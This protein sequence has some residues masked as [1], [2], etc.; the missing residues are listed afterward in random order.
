MF[1]KSHTVESV[2]N[3]N[4]EIDTMFLAWF[5]AKEKY[6]HKRELTYGEF[7]T[8]FGYD[9][10]VRVWHPKQQGLQLSDDHLKL[11]C[12]VEFEKLLSM[13]GKSLNDIESMPQPSNSEMV[14][15]RNSLLAGEL[16][17]DKEE[18]AA[19]HM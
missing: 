18:L 4:E 14:K 16:T 2:V 6:P 9:K 12:L 1:S 7:P 11:F 15:F 10:S 19:T 8:M 13:K 17:Y 3:R 5:E